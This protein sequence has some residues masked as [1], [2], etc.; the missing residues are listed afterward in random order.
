MLK[1][2]WHSYLNDAKLADVRFAARSDSSLADL[3]LPST[4]IAVSSQPLFCSAMREKHGVV[5]R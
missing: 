2:E 4:L 5:P 3:S 1:A